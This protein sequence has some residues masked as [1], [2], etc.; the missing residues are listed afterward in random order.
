[1]KIGFFGNTN[2]Y[3]FIM[4]MRLRDMGHSILQV[5][6]ETSLL[7]RPENRYSEFEKG[8]PD[9]IMDI[10]HMS[11]W[12]LMSLHPGLSR[13]LS[14][15]S[16]CDALILNATGP[17]LLPLLDKPAIALLTGSDLSNYAN[18]S[19]VSARTDVW[20]DAYK[21]SPEG[22]VHSATLRDFITRQRMGIQNAIAVRYFPRGSVPEDDRL[23]DELGIPDSKRFFFITSNLDRLDFSPPPDN[24]I[25]RIFCG[26]RLTWKLPVEAGRSPLDYK[27][28]DVMIRGLGKFFRETGVRLDIRL[29]RKGLHIP[30]TE[31]LLTE[32]GISD[33]VTWQDEMSLVDYWRE[34][35]FADIVFDQLG[36]SLPGAPALDAMAIG[37]PVIANARRDVFD[38]FEE[39]SPICHAKTPD[40]VYDHLVRLA[41]DLGE[42][43]KVGRQGR[44]YMEKYFS[45][46][47]SAH[48]IEEKISGAVKD[49]SN[50]VGT[51]EVDY[52]YLLKAR[53]ELRS[54]LVQDLMTM[55][56]ELELTQQI[57][58]QT[59][60]EL[61]RRSN[62]LEVALQELIQARDTIA[63]HEKVIRPFRL[64]VNTMKKIPFIYNRFK[65]PST[66]G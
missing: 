12:D 37:R 17:S 33:Q 10:S 7:H 24:R 40:E 35:E 38:V 8:Y 28:S 19:T 57:L 65:D 22:R 13:T 36:G 18:Y 41:R 31:Q 63:N 45:Q 21:E 15:L 48:Q 51:F 62:N 60:Q 59:R 25:V 50:D 16:K 14:E 47:W 52:E 5:V 42:R 53:F 55:S 26:A 2:N 4:A 9:W 32:E 44:R 46:E 34:I 56:R 61:E 29:V 39:A 49:L 20:R 1:M 6:T 30:E 58:D 27:G 23:L 66:H 3:P 54:D 11:E 64:L 43:A